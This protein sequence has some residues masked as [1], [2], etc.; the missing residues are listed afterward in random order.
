MAS[1]LFRTLAYVGAI[2]SSSLIGL[3]FGAAATD[4]GLHI[5]ARVLGGFGTVVVLLSALDKSIPRFAK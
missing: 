5:L 1:G 3:A 2:F 4:S